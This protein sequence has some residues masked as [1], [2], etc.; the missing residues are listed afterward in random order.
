MHDNT[1]NSPKCLIQ[2]RREFALLIEIRTHLNECIQDMSMFERK[3]LECQPRVHKHVQCNYQWIYIH[4]P[5]INLFLD[6][7]N[8]ANDSYKGNETTA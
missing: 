4:F 5:K 1:S 8:S 7:R 6:F 3:L 2:R